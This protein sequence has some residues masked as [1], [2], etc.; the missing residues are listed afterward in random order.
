[1]EVSEWNLIQLGVSP[2]VHL[3]VLG[4]VAR[5]RCSELRTGLS[6]VAESCGRFRGSERVSDVCGEP[7]PAAFKPAPTSPGNEW[8]TSAAEAF[9]QTP[10]ADRR[11]IYSFATEEIRTRHSPR[12]RADAY[13]GFFRSVYFV[14]DAI[15]AFSIHGGVIAG[16]GCAHIVVA[17]MVSL[18]V[19]SSM[20]FKSDRSDLSKEPRTTRK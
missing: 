20:G 9:A 15:L 7:P 19:T 5:L 3:R 14:N 2:D 12:M 1:M 11:P 4:G 17:R 18:A 6:E 8:V 13:R 10:S 16:Q